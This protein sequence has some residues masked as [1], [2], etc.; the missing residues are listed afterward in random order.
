MRLSYSRMIRIKLALGVLCATLVLDGWSPP[1]RAQ[2]SRT[3]TGHVVDPQDVPV[4]GARILAKDGRVLAVTDLSGQFSIPADTPAI[5]VTAPNF[6]SAS[7]IVD[8]SL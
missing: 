1:A 4:T 5:E 6:S 3:I 2:S 7:V 8:E